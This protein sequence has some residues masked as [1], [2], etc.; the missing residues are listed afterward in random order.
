MAKRSLKTLQ[1]KINS[2]TG[3]GN[4]NSYWY[5]HW[6]LPPNRNSKLRILEDPDQENDFIV[7]VEY[8]EHA[9]NIDGEYTRIPCPK[10]NGKETPCPICKRSSALYS[11]DEEKS[12]KYYYRDKY[13]FLRAL[14]TKD[15]L[16]YAE[17][18]TSATG[19]VRP[20]KFSFQLS[21]KLKAEIGKLEE[22]D[23]FWDLDAGIDF[24]IHKQMKQ[25]KGEDMADYGVASGFA[26]K[27]T[28]IDAEWREKISEEPLSTLIPTIPS[29]DEVQAL[30]D[31]HDLSNTDSSDT[32]GTSNSSDKT[33]SESDLMDTINRKRAGSTATESDSSAD[34]DALTK[35][36]ESESESE[37]DNV[38]DDA[39]TAL[40]KD[41]DDDDDF[42]AKLK[43]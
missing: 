17:G 3:E 24:E 28:S 33:K 34:V 1:G 23:V 40:M 16:E 22:E 27:E 42:L 26:R 30:L 25:V 18:E 36:A 43:F 2:E 29:F 32:S 8:L 20:I 19:Q 41:D 6:K 4:S 7:Y 10:N 21:T 39:L 11:A 12:G 31:K 38:T 9:I 15:G 35:L 13:A 37:V 5:P 14:I